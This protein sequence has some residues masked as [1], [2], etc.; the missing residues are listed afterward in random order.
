MPKQ[1]LVTSP[2]AS[3]CELLRSSLEET[4]KYAVQAA[5]SGEQALARA[6]NGRFD[7]AILD[8]DIEDQQVAALGRSLQEQ[9][10]ELLL[11]VIPPENDPQHLSMVNF[12][13][14]SYLQRPF[15]LPDLMEKLAFLLERSQAAPI[16]ETQAPPVSRAPFWL[17]GSKRAGAILDKQLR[18]TFLQAALIYGANEAPA[19]HSSGLADDSAGHLAGILQPSFTSK[20]TELAHYIK[21]D[22]QER[23][24]YAVPLADGAALAG[25][26]D[27]SVPISQARQQVQS[28]RDRLLQV[29]PEPDAGPVQELEEERFSSEDEDFLARLE[30]EAQEE[31]DEEDNSGEL[32]A[33]NLSDLLA[34]MPPPDPNR[35][36]ISMQ[37]WQHLA[38]D[39]PGEEPASGE[40]APS[41]EA[42]PVEAQAAVEEGL[43][44]PQ[45][46]KARP[47][48]QDATDVDELLLPW[49]TFDEQRQSQPETG[50]GKSPGATAQTVTQATYTCILIPRMVRHT[51]TLDMGERLKQWLPQHC[52][53]FGWSLEGMAVTAEYMQWTVRV[54]P[55]VS[56]GN[57]VRMVRQRTSEN[58][59]NQYAYL[60]EQNESGDFWAPGYLVVSGPNPPSPE[61]LRNFIYQARRRQGLYRF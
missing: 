13:P 34:E 54:T 51:L 2:Q 61:L 48:G 18:E 47:P 37:E 16:L 59:F 11:V 39:E 38:D 5:A 12:T 43:A 41:E 60:K 19:S 9:H 58:L 1:I 49:E 31:E 56:Q 28:L 27:A 4:G 22:Q 53:A 6:R 44:V 10:H 35:M 30:I 20:P 8:S 3:F 50:D 24:V 7:L 57:V 14:D 36:P 32:P 46:G 29:Q 25:L 26:L 33:I 55:S 52:L 45:N 15:Y 21:L 42:K 23:L 40:T 17:L